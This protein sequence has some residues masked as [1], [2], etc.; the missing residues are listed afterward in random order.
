MLC[1][2]WEVPA[3][4]GAQFLPCSW[5]GGQAILAQ[6]SCSAGASGEDSLMPS[7]ARAHKVPYHWPNCGVTP[8]P[9]VKRTGRDTSYIYLPDTCFLLVHFHKT[10]N[11]AP[12]ALQDGQAWGAGGG[13]LC[14]TPTLPPNAQ[15]GGSRPGLS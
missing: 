1:E 5:E 3:G 7:K 11:L 10:E 9:V 6:S 8:G 2:G 15:K 4:P 13:A 14:S 12:S